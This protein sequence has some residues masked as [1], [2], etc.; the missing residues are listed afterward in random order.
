M[1]QQIGRN[2]RMLERISEQ[3]EA[4]TAFAATSQRL[5]ELVANPINEHLS[6]SYRKLG[7]ELVRSALGNLELPEMKLP[8]MEA[9]FETQQ[10]IEHALKNLAV[11]THLRFVLPMDTVDS[12]TRVPQVSP[13]PDVEFD[14]DE[15]LDDT[16]RAITMSADPALLSQQERVLLVRAFWVFF[17]AAQLVTPQGRQLLHEYPVIWG[18]ITALVL[19]YGPRQ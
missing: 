16:Y 10:A 15:W 4:M 17:V 1:L 9:T 3:S 8:D 13:T 2:A 18:L 12:R 7:G 5:A 11:T 14:E 6:S 19:S